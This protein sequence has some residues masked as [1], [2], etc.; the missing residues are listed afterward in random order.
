MA[1]EYK[2]RSKDKDGNP[3]DKFTEEEAL[4]LAKKQG[5]EFVDE[6]RIEG[7]SFNKVFSTRKEAEKTA[8]DLDVPFSKIIQTRSQK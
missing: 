3:D 1:D 8:K 6:Y 7:D 2:H 5:I 4:K